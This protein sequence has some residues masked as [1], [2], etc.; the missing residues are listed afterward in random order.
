MVERIGEH[1]LLSVIVPVYNVAPYLR[2]CIDSIVHQ[3]YQNLEIILVIDGGC[4]DGSAEICGEY[5][6]EDK[7]IKLLRRPHEGLVS[8]R[9]AGVQAAEGEYISYVDGDDWLDADAYEKLLSSM[10]GLSPDVL[11]FGFKEEYSNKAVVVQN[12]IPF[13]YYDAGGIKDEIYQQLLKTCF[14]YQWETVPNDGGEDSRYW[15]GPRRQRRQMKIG[16]NV[17][18]RLVKRECLKESQ[19]KVPD[20]VD[21]GEDVVCTIYALLT[22]SSVMNVNLQPYHY[23]VRSDSASRSA[24]FKQYQT[25]FSAAFSA[26]QGSPMRKVHAGRLY[27][28]LCPYVLLTR[29]EAFLEGRFSDILFGS[30]DDC[31]V[32]LYGAGK[33]GQEIYYK[34]EAVFPERITLWV[35]RDYAG[36]QKMRMPVEPVEELLKREYDVVIISLVNEEVC[37]EIKHTLI[38]FGIASEK[39]RYAAVSAELVEAVEEIL[40][41]TGRITLLD[42]AAD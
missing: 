15:R 10:G 19:M 1:P 22:A 28:F 23:R 25:L 30:L 34:T 32:A 39:I 35:D 20:E 31:R 36:Y 24:T 11:L 13:E 41:G 8:S 38:G 26:L 5:A 33:F 27:E 42:G 16:M 18:N 6:A 40:T 17:W 2:Q 12:M 37:E 29:Y 7:R 14:P 21:I 4:S 3:T 9:K